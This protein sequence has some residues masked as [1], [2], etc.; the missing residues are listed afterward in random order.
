MK[1]A[2]SA[3]VSQHPT[4][5][6]EGERASYHWFKMPDLNRATHRRLGQCGA[7]W[8]FETICRLVH[9][10]GRVGRPKAKK[11]AREF[12][13]LG[14]GLHAIADEAG[15]SVAKARRDLVKLVDLGLVAVSRRN[16]TFHIDPAT[17]KIVENRT[18]RSLPVTVFLTV[19]PEHCRTKAGQ[20]RQAASPTKMAPSSPAILEGP[21]LPDRDHFGGGIQRERNS[22]RRPNGGAVST[23]TP[24]AEPGAGLPAG[25][26]PGTR[27][28]AATACGLPEA[29]Q[30]R[31]PAAK[32]AGHSAGQAGQEMVTVRMDADHDDLPPAV[33]RISRPA[34]K[35]PSPPRRHERQLPEDHGIEHRAWQ[36]AAEE[37]R[38][39]MLAEMERRRQADALNPPI[40]QA[41]PPLNATQAA[42]ALQAAVDEL[43]PASRRKARKAAKKMSAAERQAEAEAKALADLIEKKKRDTAGAAKASAEAFA[44]QAR[45]AWR[46]KKSK[47]SEAVA[48]GS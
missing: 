11:A 30:R 40:R 20:D 27:E 25:E 31:L 28:Q 7:G 38:L 17:G 26:E 42:A 10:V 2:V 21:G 19:A 48:L 8:T 13:R 1:A 24:P 15:I 36:G 34:G 4:T 32:A 45:K 9:H 29:S 6:T 37:S 16:V 23:G 47:A 46:N 44:D 3:D 33:G 18:G 41:T 22:E 35:A 14:V 43:P 12:G 39:R 5:A